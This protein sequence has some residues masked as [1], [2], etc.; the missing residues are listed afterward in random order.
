MQGLIMLFGIVISVMK[1]GFFFRDKLTVASS[2]F[3]IPDGCRTLGL[4]L[5]V[6]DP[7]D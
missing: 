3:N 1:F 2:V 6:S 4:W 7:G 5:S